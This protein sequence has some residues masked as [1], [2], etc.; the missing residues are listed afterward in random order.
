MGEAQE[1]WQAL[2]S[3]NEDLIWNGTR[4]LDDE[5]ITLLATEIVREVKE[6]GP[7]LTLSDFINRRLTDD[8]ETRHG[9]AGPLEAAIQAAGL[10][11]ALYAGT[12]MEID[13]ETSL[14]EYDHPDNITQP[15][16]L[17][18]TMK[19]PSSAWGAP[20][21]LTQADV[22]QAIGS[23]L[24]A[25]SDT[26][27]IRCYGESTDGYGAVKARAWC[28]AV[29]QRMPEPMRPDDT[30]LN[31]LEENGKPN[32]GRRFAIQSFRWLNPAE[33]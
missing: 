7:F 16:R 24:S 30:G 18:Q 2:D 9:L 5:E 26:F 15:T 3:P 29:V 28:E 27:T 19:P 32:F 11:E 8:L 23:S 31:S 21:Y 33:V 14:N 12:S 6:R 4:V 22:L 1:E 20:V 13:R 25:R 17:E 10:N